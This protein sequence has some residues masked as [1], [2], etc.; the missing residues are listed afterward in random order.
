MVPDLIALSG[1]S[2]IAAVVITLPLHCGVSC[3]HRHAYAATSTPSKVLASLRIT[4]DL[5]R[6]ELL[7]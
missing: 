5:H 3:V 1:G 4:K 7:P 6:Y 2:V